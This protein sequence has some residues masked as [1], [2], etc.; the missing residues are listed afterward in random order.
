MIVD[1]E[2]SAVSDEQKMTQTDSPV[3]GC[4]AEQSDALVAEASVAWEI[5]GDLAHSPSDTRFSLTPTSFD[6]A[7]FIIK[8]IRPSSVKT[9]KRSQEMT[10]VAYK[11]LEP[12]CLNL[13]QE[14]PV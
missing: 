2:V 3:S 14:R 12:E 11:S 13:K 8:T 4:F 10:L 6:E 5:Q 7:Y 9:L 1:F